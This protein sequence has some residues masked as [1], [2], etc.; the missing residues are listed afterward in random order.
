MAKSANAALTKLALGVAG[1]AALA[2]V[3]GRL[4]TANPAPTPSGT[5]VQEQAQAPAPVQDSAVLQPSLD[6]APSGARESD[7]HFFFRDDEREGDH[8]REHD[9]DGG[10]RDDH[11]EWSNQEGQGFV[12]VP[13]QV[14]QVSQVPQSPQPSQSLQ[15]S[16]RSSQ[17]QAPQSGTVVQP[18]SPRRTRTRRS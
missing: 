7:E 4:A 8:E 5:D 2:G 16:Q 10:E 15:P 17:L 9:E 11:E 13:P 18:A 3:T 14:S 6:Q 12:L 1:V